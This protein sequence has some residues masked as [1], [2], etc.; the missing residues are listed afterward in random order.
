[1]ASADELL[2]LA[3][4]EDGE[5]EVPLAEAAMKL[6]VAEERLRDLEPTPA[7]SPTEAI[8]AGGGVGSPGAPELGGDGQLAALAQDRVNY[9]ISLIGPSATRKAGHGG[10]GRVAFRVDERGYVRDLEIRSST[11]N[12]VLDGEIEPALH[13]AEPFAV[14]PEWISVKVHFDR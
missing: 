2:D 5:A 4:T 14:T 6:A 11:G 12:G 7:V 3:A 8:P 13:L 10:T 1:L 9:V